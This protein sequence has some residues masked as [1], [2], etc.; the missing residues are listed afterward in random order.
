MFSFRS[1]GD[2]EEE[3]EMIILSEITEFYTPGGRKSASYF[4]TILEKAKGISWVCATKEALF[5]AI[6][7]IKF[8]FL[9]S[10]ERLGYSEGCKIFK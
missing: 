5:S 4:K 10:C 1:R 6:P 3:L 9:L 8:L 7:K 2:V